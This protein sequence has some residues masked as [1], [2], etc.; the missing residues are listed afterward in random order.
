MIKVDDS[1]AAT[2]WR[3]NLLVASALFVTPPFLCILAFWI[4]AGFSTGDLVELNPQTIIVASLGSSCAAIAPYW[5]LRLLCW[6]EIRGV[7]F[8]GGHR[9]W[10]ITPA[11][12]RSVIAHSSVGWVIGG[13]LW[14]LGIACL[15]VLICC[16]EGD[17]IFSST[18]CQASALFP[19]VGLLMGLL[20]FESLVFIGIRACRFANAPE[21]VA[22]YLPPAQN[23][24][25]PV[26]PGPPAE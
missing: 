20:I 4:A 8:F 9:G 16:V 1:Q 24:T 17:M 11:L 26:T 22:R 6:I 5:V 19:F 2:I 3:F 10:R 7:Q 25:V 21:I 12:A 15:F 23:S 18:L 13:L 14:A